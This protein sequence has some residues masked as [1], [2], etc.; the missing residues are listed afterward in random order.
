M[1]VVFGQLCRGMA[2]GVRAVN[3]NTQVLKHVHLS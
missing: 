2:L 1:L 3:L